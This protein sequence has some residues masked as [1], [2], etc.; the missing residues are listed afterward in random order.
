MVVTRSTTNMSEI[1]E[2]VKAYFENLVQSFA[3]TISTQIDELLGKLSAQEKEIE[4]LKTKNVEQDNAIEVLQSGNL[5][6][7]NTIELLKEKIDDLEQYQ[8]RSSVRIHGLAAAKKG[9]REN[10]LK[11][12]EQC[13]REMDL[14]FEPNEINRVH[15]IGPVNTNNGKSTQ[16]IIV[17]FR[18]WN[19][20]CNFF[21]KRPRFDPA[22]NGRRFTVG[23]DL[24]KRRVD[25]LH[26]A[27]EKIKEYPD[28]SYSFCDL[29]C[30][31]G[32]K[33]DDD[34]K[35]F[36]NSKQLTSILQDYDRVE[37]TN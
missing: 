19:A 3:K 12:V 7:N 35:Y 23:L 37:S 17:Q 11:V 30:K 24:T 1:S 13:H 29:N 9:E 22:N 33:I 16:S 31:L 4:E 6:K 2:E 32:L 36:N 34:T 14:K 20:R 10:V 27:R 21:K 28:V 26:Q 15:R 25:L 18:S 5:L 8:R